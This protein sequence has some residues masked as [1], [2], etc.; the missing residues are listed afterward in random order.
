MPTGT[1]SD[2]PTDT[3]APTSGGGGGGGGAPTDTIAPTSG[4]GGGNTNTLLCN[5]LTADSSSSTSAPFTVNFTVV[6]SDS[7]STVNGINF[8]FGDGS[9]QNLTSGGGIGTG[10]INAQISHTY[11]TNG[12]YNASAVLTDNTGATSSS[13]SCLQAI[14]VGTNL[15]T[16]TPT[17]TTS[18][19]PLTQMKTGPGDKFVILGGIGGIITLVGAAILFGL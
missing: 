8:N 11:Q 1:P 19:A 4:G 5:S 7:T 17:P 16:N 13:S 10:S 9:T 14:T 15:P 6:G 12:A 3:I 18:S 2:T